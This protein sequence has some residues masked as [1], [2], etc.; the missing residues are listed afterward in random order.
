[1]KKKIKSFV[2]KV[3]TIGFLAL[4]CL[5]T[6]ASTKKCLKGKNPTQQEIKEAELF[7]LERG[8]KRWEEV[9][10]G[11]AK[12]ELSNKM[13]DDLDKAIE[14]YSLTELPTLALCSEIN[15]PQ[16]TLT[17]LLVG[18]RALNVA[19]PVNHDYIYNVKLL[20]NILLERPYPTN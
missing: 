19:D 16:D 12:Q 2:V 4:L 18:W 13:G 8:E 15:L 20:T 5:Q 17:D 6:E 11:D 9:R 3:T 7:T 10:T 14:I 1:M